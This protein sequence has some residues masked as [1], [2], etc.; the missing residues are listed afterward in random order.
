MHKPD[1]YGVGLPVVYVFWLG[2][3]FA[4]YP[5]CRWF[6]ALKQRRKDGWAELG[7]SSAKPH[8]T[9][10]LRAGVRRR[11]PVGQSGFYR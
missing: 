10:R 6:A 11:G 4:S 8:A 2:I 9:G 3:V 5:L 7:L 1:G